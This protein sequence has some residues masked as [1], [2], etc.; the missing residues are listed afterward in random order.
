MIYTKLTIRA[1]QLAYNAHKGQVDKGGAP[2]IIH[3]LYVAEQMTD[4]LSTVVALLHDTVED[5]AV[6]IKDIQNQ[7]YPY[8]VVEAL[9]LLTKPRNVSYMDYIVRIKTN[10]IATKVKIADLKHNMMLTRLVGVGVTEKDR[11]RIQK[12]AQALKYLSN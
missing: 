11:I 8:E 2:Y 9:A 5:T 10:V 7:G 4:E 12:Y 6:T 3:P 1:M